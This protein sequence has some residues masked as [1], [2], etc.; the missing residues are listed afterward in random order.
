MIKYDDKH[1]NVMP[2]VKFNFLLGLTSCHKKGIVKINIGKA[3]M[4][5]VLLTAVNQHA[6]IIIK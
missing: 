6:V 5:S 4:P 3:V 1:I 2:S